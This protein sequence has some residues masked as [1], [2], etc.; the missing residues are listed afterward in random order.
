MIQRNLQPRGLLAE[1]A[2]ALWY[3]DGYTAPHALERVLPDGATQL[4]VHLRGDPLRV[5]DRAGK[6]KSISGPLVTGPRARYSLVDVAQ[7]GSLMGI[8]FRPGSAAS[9]LGVPATALYDTDVPL[10]ALWGASALTLQARIVE[11]QT[12]EAR[13]HL[14]ASALL[15]RAARS[16]EPNAT[17]LHTARL[18]DAPS[19]APAIADVAASVG[20]SHRHFIARFREAV[21]LSPKTYAR[22]RRFQAAVRSAAHGKPVPWAQLAAQVGYYDQAHLAHDF[23]EFAG[24]APSH[25]LPRRSDYHNHVPEDAKLVNFLQD[26]HEPI[27]RD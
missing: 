14:L 21:G 10:E 2:D 9:L 19:A 11:T 23:R 3:Y 8:H 13:L 7:Q 25:Y 24:F 15:T 12:P 18:L 20:L 16:P 4:I 17:M 1:F 26:T 6:P 5:F 27:E 22:V